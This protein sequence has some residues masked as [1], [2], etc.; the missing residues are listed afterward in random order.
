MEKPRFSICLFVL[1]KILL[2]YTDWGAGY[3]VGSTWTWRVVNWFPVVYWRCW[4]AAQLQTLCSQKNTAILHLYKIIDKLEFHIT[5][6]MHATHVLCILSSW[7][8]FGSCPEGQISSR[9][10]VCLPK[11]AACDST[12]PVNPE[13]SKNSSYRHIFPSKTHSMH[14]RKAIILSHN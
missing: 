13:L 6:K 9:T 11:Q 8:Y 7:L 12:L 1:F 10:P 5:V 4:I 14:T 3:T 2:H